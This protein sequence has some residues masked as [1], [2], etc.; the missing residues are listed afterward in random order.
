[1]TGP[2]RLVVYEGC[3]HAVGYVDSTNIGPYPSAVIADW[4]A[5]TLAGRRSFPSEHWF[6]SANGRVSKEGFGGRS[7]AMGTEPGQERGGTIRAPSCR[8]TASLI[9]S[10]RGESRGDVMGCVPAER[11]ADDGLYE[12]TP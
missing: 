1:M 3:N 8:G 6:V 11:F 9:G 5:A 7:T 12:A 10:G 4:M 2:R